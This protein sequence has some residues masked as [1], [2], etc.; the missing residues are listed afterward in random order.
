MKFH[1][2]T[3]RFAFNKGRGD[4]SELTKEVHEAIGLDPNS[5]VDQLRPHLTLVLS[6]SSGL[7]DD[8]ELTE[9]RVLKAEVLYDGLTPFSRRGW[10][11]HPTGD[12]QQP[13]RSSVY[14]IIRF[15]FDRPVDEH[16]VV[17]ALN[18]S[19]FQLMTEQMKALGSEPF[20]LFDGAGFTEI[21]D[22][23]SEY[24]L[25]DELVADG[26]LSRDEET[27]DVGVAVLAFSAGMET[28]GHAVDWP[29]WCPQGR[30]PE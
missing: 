3:L 28:G 16:A 14:P 11:V 30:P 29:A 9:A 15:T 18:Q 19:R 6:F 8:L 23:D 13:L 7:A 21:V 12:S 27:W 26:L 20:E 17:L 25:L 24:I 1:I 2:Q 22:E 5:G 4:P 10:G